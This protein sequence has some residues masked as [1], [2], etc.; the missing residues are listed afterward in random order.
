VRGTAG[1]PPQ[2]NTHTHTQPLTTPPS[3]NNTTQP[4]IVERQRL[5]VEPIVVGDDVTLGAYGE[6]FPAA[7]AEDGARVGDSAVVMT[8]EHVGAGALWAGIPAAPL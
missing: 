2:K 1:P 7:T 3:P 4:K 8:G 5:F 6:I